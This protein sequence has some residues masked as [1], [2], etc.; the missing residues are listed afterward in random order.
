MK[1]TMPQEFYNSYLVYIVCLFIGTL[2]PVSSY[3]TLIVIT[4]SLF[5]GAV[6]GC[7]F[8]MGCIL[9]KLSNDGL[10]KWINSKRWGFLVHI[11]LAIIP[12]YFCMYPIGYL[13]PLDK[14]YGNYT[15][16]KLV[17]NL[18]SLSEWSK[19]LDEVHDFILKRHNNWIY[20][21]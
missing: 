9:S 3:A 7:A 17:W 2:N 16:Q 21:F 14:E 20:T 19:G 8:M 15:L 1:R 12:I 13:E 5:W 18:P 11:L 4:L 10:F 6:W